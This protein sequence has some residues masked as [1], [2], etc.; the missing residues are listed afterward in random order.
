MPVLISL[1]NQDSAGATLA[2][3]S[4][5]AAREAGEPAIALQLL[6]CPKTDVLPRTASRKAL[7]TGYFLEETTIA[8]AVKQ[9]CPDGTDLS[10]WRLSPLFAP[11]LEGLPPAI[12]HTAEFDPLRDEG[13]AFA[14]RLEASGVP[15]HYVCHA[16]MIHHFYG[17]TG[18]IPYARQALIGIGRDLAQALHK[19]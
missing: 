8:W 1:L 18:V 2:I 4:C 10:D 7:A 17:M 3:A 5:L 13:R 14:D 6:L 12:V 11:S 16:G 9:L 19:E 15:A